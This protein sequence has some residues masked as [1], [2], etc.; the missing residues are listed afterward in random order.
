MK[1]NKNRR[2]R[3]SNDSSINYQIENQKESIDIK[4][5]LTNYL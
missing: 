2:N 3:L 1:V 5:E 4:K